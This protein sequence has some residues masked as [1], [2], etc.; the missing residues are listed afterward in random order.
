MSQSH[1]AR[2]QQLTARP[3]RLWT[4]LIVSSLAR[5]ILT[6][7]VALGLWAALPAVWGWI[8]TTVSS[9][10]MAPN[11]RAGDVVVA[12][13]I[14]SDA[15]TPGQVLL[16]DDPGRDGRL[17]LHRFVAYAADGSLITRGDANPDNDAATIAVDAVHGIGV[18]RVPWVGLPGMWLQKG[19]ILPLAVTVVVVGLLIW[20]SR[21]DTKH[22]RTPRGARRAAPVAATAAIAGLLLA[23]V[24]AP[25]T[26]ASATFSTSTVNPVSAFTA[27]TPFSC[28]TKTVSNAPYLLYRFTE[29]SGTAATDSSANGRTGAL[30][31]GATR[32]P[33]SCVLDDS[34]TLALNGSTGYVSTPN[35]LAAPNVFSTEIWFKTTTTSGG[36][37]IAMG[38]SQLGASTTHDRHLYMTNAG[39]LV[40]GVNNGTLRTI[41][42]PAAYND[43]AWHLAV[44]TLS[45]A[46][47]RL[48]VDGTLRVSSTLATSGIAY[49]GWWKIGYETLTGWPS[50]PTSSFF[51]G[52]IDSVAT[53]STARTA[54]QVTARYTAGR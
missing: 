30:Q 29:V 3:S 23:A 45:G 47:M 25:P 22:F 36:T 15:L 24:V 9:E 43:G 42:T 34:P 5:A 2:Q 14:P 20:M 37:L 17:L 13:P 10:S 32:V 1:S 18:V 12:A 41:T 44:T 49:T 48:Y 27:S 35:S 52:E 28:L 8:P 4:V 38:S 33:G 51:S 7:A 6:V 39:T 26:P 16:A 19:D 46:G 54:A 50:A 21:L 53:Y 40:F 11:I 31:G